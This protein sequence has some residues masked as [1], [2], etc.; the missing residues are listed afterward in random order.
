MSSK[1]SD[2]L[3]EVTKRILRVLP[4][5][6]RSKAGEVAHPTVRQPMFQAFVKLSEVLRWH[7]QPCKMP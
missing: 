2:A 6:G 3:N 1:Y 7:L 4:D 5:G